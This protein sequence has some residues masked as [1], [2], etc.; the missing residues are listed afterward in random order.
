L[1][2]G[3]FSSISNIIEEVISNS[4]HIR[5]LEKDNFKI[6]FEPREFI[7]GILFVNNKSLDLRHRLHSATNAFCDTFVSDIERIKQGKGAVEIRDITKIAIDHFHT[8]KR[9]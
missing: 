9:K 8:R 5:E 4:G 3:A 7:T 2:G 1:I 6:I